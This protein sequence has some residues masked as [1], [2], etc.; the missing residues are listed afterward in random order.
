[1]GLFG[2]LGHWLGHKLGWRSTGDLQ[3]IQ[4]KIDQAN[5]TIRNDLAEVLSAQ[6][7]VIL[8][9]SSLDNQMS[10]LRH[11]LQPYCE[12]YVKTRTGILKGDE[13]NPPLMNAGLLAQGKQLIALATGEKVF[14]CI[15]D[16]D[17]PKDMSARGPI[18]CDT[19]TGCHSLLW[20]TRTLEGFVGNRVWRDRNK[21]VADACGGHSYEMKLHP[22]QG[23]GMD[24][25]KEASGISPA[26]SSAF[27]LIPLVLTSNPCRET[28][29]TGKP[30]NRVNEFL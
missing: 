6:D 9:R 24:D 10:V 19:S 25:A 12:N 18:P 15:N 17:V 21:E 26:E 5:G 23:W 29:M 20:T 28:A 16:C 2:N 8:A 7:Q 4:E 30:R 22:P 14:G 1:M 11:S 13:N 27:A 3:A